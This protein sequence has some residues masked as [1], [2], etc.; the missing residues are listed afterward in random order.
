MLNT[1]PNGQRSTSTLPGIAR[2]LSR[3]RSESDLARILSGPVRT[4]LK[5]EAL[6]VITRSPAPRTELDSAA[7]RPRVVHAAPAAILPLLEAGIAAPLDTED[8]RIASLHVPPE[9]VAVEIVPCAGVASRSALCICRRTLGPEGRADDEQTL[10]LAAM[11]GMTLDRLETQRRVSREQNRIR[12]VA[13]VIRSVSSRS[14]AEAETLED[15]EM[16]F[17][18]RLD[19]LIRSQ[20]A[21]SR[22]PEGRLEFEDIVRDELLAEGIRDGP[23]V[24]IKGMPITLCPVETEVLGFAIHELAVNAIKFGPFSDRGGTLSV[25]WWAETASEGLRLHIDWNETCDTP[26]ER[27]PERR[28]FGRQYIERAVPYELG[29][30]TAF[31]LQPEG[32][33]CLI[34]LVLADE[35]ALT[36][37]PGATARRSR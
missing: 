23:R 19:T 27:M 26:L 16:H 21:I 10:L 35:E 22:A 9:A 7:H 32:M 31:R 28:G 4:F 5:A 33:S 8:E 14:A 36:T 29:A 3:C 37:G 6:L 24:S 15:F 25:R 18:G 17:D 13:A 2:E 11:A 12:N 1:A 20:V 34:R 30:E